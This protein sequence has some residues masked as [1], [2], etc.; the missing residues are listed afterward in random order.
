MLTNGNTKPCAYPPTVR[1]FLDLFNSV[2]GVTPRSYL[3][4]PIL[5][6]IHTVKIS[7]RL[8]NICRIPCFGRRCDQKYCHFLCPS[9]HVQDAAPVKSVEECIQGLW[10]CSTEDQLI[11]PWRKSI[12]VPHGRASGNR[13]STTLTQS[14]QEYLDPSNPFP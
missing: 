12:C 3:V 1:W 9:P 10:S 5:V 6:Q 4:S 14:T 11:K 2:A 13:I 8:K 7:Y